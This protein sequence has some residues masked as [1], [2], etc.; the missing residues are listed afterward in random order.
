MISPTSR[1]CFFLS[2]LVLL[3]ERLLSL[4]LYWKGL[5]CQKWY[6]HLSF[7]T[8]CAGKQ[9]P[10]RV[11][12][13]KALQKFS[14]KILS[15]CFILTDCKECVCTTLFLERYSFKS[16]YSFE[17]YTTNMIKFSSILLE[18][19]CR[20]QFKA[21]DI[22]TYFLRTDIVH[23]SEPRQEKEGPTGTKGW[24][25]QWMEKGRSDGG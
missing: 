15:H 21:E 22:C 19:G 10:L 3:C 20:R 18:T 5:T 1:S 13:C 2:F 17:S 8:Q 25:E 23:I 7:I 16:L 6:L 11:L 9:H 24:T 12:C 14:S 4:L